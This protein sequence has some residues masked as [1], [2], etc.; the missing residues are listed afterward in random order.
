[1]LHFGLD[2]TDGEPPAFVKQLRDEA[3]AENG[4]TLTAIN[5]R[6]EALR[7][8][9]IAAFAA[10]IRR[11]TGLGQLTSAQFALQMIEGVEK[12]ALLYGSPSAGGD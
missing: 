3:G 4:P 6:D 5:W 8:L 12:V 9:D 7:V 1:M 10:E 2:L 11:V